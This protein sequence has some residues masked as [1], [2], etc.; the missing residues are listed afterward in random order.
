M[1][2]F[3]ELKKLMIEAD[4]SVNHLPVLNDTDLFVDIW[5][6]YD[7]ISWYDVDIYKMIT[8]YKYFPVV[9]NRI[10]NGVITM[11][12]S[13]HISKTDRKKFIYIP[14]NSFTVS[15]CEFS[16]KQEVCNVSFICYQDTYGKFLILNADKRLCKNPVSEKVINDLRHNVIEYG[17][18]LMRF[19]NNNLVKTNVNG[20]NL[21]FPLNN[22][23][24]KT[25]FKN[26]DTDGRRK[27]LIYTV[28]EYMRKSKT[29]KII[30]VSKHIRGCS[31]LKVNGK[32]Y[33]I[34]VGLQ[35]KDF[36]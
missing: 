20:Y 13:K 32:D 18:S 1:R 12:I 34:L 25:V 27:P 26:R 6:G 36:F 8:L 4:L 22:E 30:N 5:E 29:G 9:L 31:E 7:D 35:N 19:F 28:D 2:S 33:T 21:Y 11:T 14:K 24:C 23:E 17:K 16:K 3:G 10:N 15:I